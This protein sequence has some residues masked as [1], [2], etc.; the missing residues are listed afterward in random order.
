MISSAQN[1]FVKLY[2]SLGRRKVRAEQF[3]LPL[4]G[5]NL[6]RDVLERQIMPEIIYLRQGFGFDHFPF[7]QGMS[8]KTAVLYIEEKLFDRIAFT[9]SPQGIL[10][11]VR[12]P[13]W[14]FVDIFTPEHALLLIVDGVQ[15]PGNLGT[16][17]RSAAAAGAAGIILLPG[18]VDAT[19]PKAL[20]AAMGAYFALPVVEMEPNLCLAEL[21]K[22]DISLITTAARADMSYE[23]YNWRT[24]AAIVIGNE[25]AGISATFTNAAETTI[26]IPMAGSVESLNAA[27]AMSVIFFEAAR[28]RR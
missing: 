20:R 13:R 8:N 9:E 6:I 24:R 15:D 26:S 5:E 23:Q 3:L 21:K 27:I 22:H 1:Q 16:M 28:Q 14:S 7:L 19:N 17:F 18:T 4:E 11:V 2:R 10:A 25:G 12:R